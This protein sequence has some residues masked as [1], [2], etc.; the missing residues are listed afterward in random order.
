MLASLLLKNCILARRTRLVIY[1]CDV[2]TAYSLHTTVWNI[3]VINNTLPIRYT[4][5]TLACAIVL[6]LHP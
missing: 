6:F 1:I 3:L 4:N 5:L 2:G